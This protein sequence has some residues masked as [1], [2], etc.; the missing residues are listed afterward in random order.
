MEIGEK[1]GLLHI[2]V[3][4]V[5]SR[6]LWYLRTWILVYIIFSLFVYYYIIQSNSF[7]YRKLHTK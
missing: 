6:F 1:S 5:Y 7:Q 2:T 3:T 4:V